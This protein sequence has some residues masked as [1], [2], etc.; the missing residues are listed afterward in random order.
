M[1]FRDIRHVLFCVLTLFVGIACCLYAGHSLLVPYVVAAVFFMLGVH[2]IAGT[3][4]NIGGIT[5][6]LNVMSVILVLIPS[7]SIVV[8]EAQSRELGTDA[9]DV[10]VVPATDFGEP[11]KPPDIYYVVFDRYASAAT[12]K[13]AFDFDNT[14]FLRYLSD[15]GFYVAS[16]SRSRANPT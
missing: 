7:V 1:L 11:H 5:S 3:Q 4:R 12:L 6:I 9:P 15:K 2:V 8:H 16:E 14:E 10:V 13:E